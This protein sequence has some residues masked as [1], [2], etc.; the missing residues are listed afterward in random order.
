MLPVG[1]PPTSRTRVTGKGL[2]RGRIYLNHCCFRFRSGGQPMTK[3][4]TQHHAVH[5]RVGLTANSA[6]PA[7]LF[8]RF[9]PPR[10]HCAGRLLAAPIAT[11]AALVLHRTVLPNP[12]NTPFMTYFPAVALA[13]WLAGPW[14]GLAAVLLTAATVDYFFF[15][16]GAL[17]TLTH[18]ELVA[19]VLYVCSASGIAILCGSLHAAM[20]R[21][22]ASAKQI[23]EGETQYRS[24]FENMREGLAYC[25]MRFHDGQ[26]EDFMYLAVNSS[27]ERQTG[28]K[29]VT[30]KWV[31]KVIP[32]IREA[33]PKLFAIYGRVAKSGQPENFEM[34]VQALNMWFEISVYCPKPEHFVAIFDVITERKR[35]E[36]QLRQ[37][38]KMEALGRL[39]G[40]VAHDFNNLL[41]AITGNLS[42]AMM[43]VDERHSI[44]ECLGDAKDAAG[45]AANLTRQ[46]LAFSR[47]QIV[48]PRVFDLNNAL[49]NMRKMLSRIIG[50]HIDLKCCP[51]ANLG[52]VKV[53]PGQLEQVLV[54]LAVN[55]AD[56]MPD[57]GN[58]TV[59]TDNVVLDEQ[60][61]RRHPEATPGA[62]VMLAV[63]DNGCGMSFEVSCQCLE[64]FFTT[65]DADRGTGLG[66]S[67]VY[68]IVKQARG[69]LE[70]YSEV[71]RGTTVK[72]YLPR[73][74]EEAGPFSLPV[75]SES[76]PKGQETVLL[77]ED[78]RN[79]RDVALRVLNRLGYNVMDFTDPEVALNAANNFPGEIHLLLTDV[80]MPRMNGRQLAEALRATRPQLRVLY[81]SGYTANV[82]VHHGVLDSGIY[83]IGKPYAAQNLAAKVREI[84][85]VA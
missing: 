13:A 84:L 47:K 81:T 39:A 79:V 4:D 43:E 20:R 7:P 76:M 49:E 28:L 15:S 80:V 16:P 70:I 48:E 68:G 6:V 8:S 82:I 63:S 44:H 59:E 3:N 38:Q 25:R 85:D 55:A 50:E 31:T 62:Y 77:V 36:E 67:T 22:E 52:S 10:L 53:D 37:A 12:S 41:T 32:G 23:V 69:T 64:P 2:A 54:N 75:H 74:E 56:A 45:N 57:G 40:G 73:I 24:L 26:A 35:L 11:F 21:A 14:S 58:L 9:A 72:V 83:F 5:K 33:D 27:F 34:H 61:C 18:G 60:Y 46:L 51:K 71:G 66:L 78:D 1:A 42:L 19:E 29:N 65:K 17:L 30:G